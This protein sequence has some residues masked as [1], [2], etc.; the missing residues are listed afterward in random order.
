MLT[1]CSF[2]ESKGAAGDCD[3]GDTTP[4]RMTGV[5]SHSH[6]RYEKSPRSSYTGLYPQRDGTCCVQGYL[7]HKKQPP[8]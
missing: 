2:D 3:S 4:C 6:V 7:A 8:P 1:V 5:T